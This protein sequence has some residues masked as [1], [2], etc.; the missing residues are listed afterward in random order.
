MKWREGVGLDAEERE[1]WAVVPASRDTF[2]KTRHMNF[3]EGRF[4]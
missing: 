1:I 3:D 2:V 4:A